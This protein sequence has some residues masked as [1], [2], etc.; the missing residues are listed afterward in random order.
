VLFGPR[1]D[2]TE[3]T[4]RPPYFHRNAVTEFNG[5]IRTPGS[6]NAPF[7]AGAYFLTPS[8][9][10][11]GVRA[12]AVERAL[13]KTDEQANQPDRHQHASLWFQ[14]ETMLPVALSRWA[15]EADN[16]IRD[17]HQSWGAYR[18]HYDPTKV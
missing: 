10:A 17:W 12:S 7:E 3:G 1:W 8:M 16:R 11:H 4:F 13:A 2:V 5:I 14:F 18:T 9:T 15:L 6:A